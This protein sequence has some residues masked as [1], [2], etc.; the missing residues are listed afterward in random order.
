MPPWTDEDKSVIDALRKSLLDIHYRWLSVEELWFPDAEEMRIIHDYDPV[1]FDVMLRC[2]F[3]DFLVSVARFTDHEKTGK[4][5]NLTLR[6]GM[7]RFLTAAEVAQAETELG[8]VWRKVKAFRDLSLAHRDYDLH[9][10]KASRSVDAISCGEIR[11]FLKVLCA[12]MGR[13]DKAFD[14]RT[15]DYTGRLRQGSW[16][17]IFAGLLRAERYQSLVF[18]AVEGHPITA[19]DLN[20]GGEGQA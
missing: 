11:E 4:Y 19:A 5:R 8:P 6:T 10:G 7:S 14:G 16:K 17:S 15:Q 13:I 3:D 18:R 12:I 2:Q 1:F 9:V 20:F